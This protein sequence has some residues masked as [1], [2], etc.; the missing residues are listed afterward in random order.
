MGKDLAGGNKKMV[1]GKGGR[2][3][4]GACGSEANLMIED[5]DTAGDMTKLGALVCKNC[6][7]TEKIVI[8]EKVDDALKAV[9][10]AL[11]R[12][13]EAHLFYK[14]S[15]QKTSSEKGRDM[16]NELA[17]FEMNHYKKMVH[18][19]HSLQKS[20]RWISYSGEGE[21][22]PDR[23]IEESQAQSDTRNDD[24]DAVTMAIKKEEEAKAFYEEM[25]EKTEDPTG[26]EM[27]TKLAQEEE[28]HRRVLND[29]HYALSNKG[30]WL[31]GD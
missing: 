10:L 26:R 18:L 5:L 2:P 15:A 4:C 22:R 25:S 14:K 9:S 13:K 1:E 23:Q 6:R 20:G 27:F 21:M 29:Q 3:I 30:V 19:C 8:P 24:I 12:E 17:A 31:W 16:F 28:I 7:S 11:K